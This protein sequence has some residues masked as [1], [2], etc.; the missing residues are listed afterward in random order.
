[1]ATYDFADTYRAAGLAPGPEIIRLRLEPFESLRKELN[2][3]RAVDLTRLYF[4]LSKEAPSWFRDAFAKADPSFSMLD[5]ER[6]AAVLASC[7]LAAGLEDEIEAAGL[8]P[9]T[10]AVGGNRA[11]LVRPDL[12]DQA[13]EALRS[14]SVAARRHS[15]VDPKTITLPA[16]SKVS[17]AADALVPSPDWAKAAALFKQVSAETFSATKTLSAQVYRVILPMAERLAD[18]EEEVAILWWYVGGWSRVLDRAFSELDPGLAAAMAGMDLGQLTR[19]APGPAAAPAIL[20]RVVTFGRKSKA[21]KVAIKDVV[22]AFPAESQD[23]LQLPD[24]LTRVP[25]VCPVLTAFSKAAEVGETPAWQRPFLKA[26][27]LDAGVS[28]LP[29]ELAMQVYRETL[30]VSLLD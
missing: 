17:E 15:E 4:G 25:D 16:T 2:A 24:A 30:L 27:Q 5:N 23:R 29:A 9:L 14:M 11:P 12:V 18:L 7:L 6:E 3:E 13:R 19:E 8:A 26:A 10:A 28:M 21:S 1:M 20:H 22:D